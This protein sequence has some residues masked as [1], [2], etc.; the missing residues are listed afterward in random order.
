MQSMFSASS[1]SSNPATLLGTT[2]DEDYSNRRESGQGSMNQHRV[3]VRKKTSSLGAGE[4]VMKRKTSN[5]SERTRK[6]S[7]KQRQDKTQDSVPP[8]NLQQAKTKR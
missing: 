3:G 2:K 7:A 8:L 6:N 1:R 4:G 5:L